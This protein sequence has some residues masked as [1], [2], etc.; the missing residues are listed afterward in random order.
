MATKCRV[1]MT[2]DKKGRQAYWESK[3]LNITD[4]KWFGP[5][6]SR[7][8]AQAKERTLALVHGCKA[9]PGGRDPKGNLQ[10]WVYKF[11]YTESIF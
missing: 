7:E 4:W 9:H 10:W 6:D 5:Y 3:I 11:T 1:G 8:K 2:T